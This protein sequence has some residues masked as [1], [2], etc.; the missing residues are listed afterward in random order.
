MM[1]RSNPILQ[2]KVIYLPS[3][4]KKMIDANKVC[5]DNLNKDILSV[6]D[7]NY[8]ESA[9]NKKIG[10]GLFEWLGFKYPVVSI[11]ENSDCGCDIP[12]ET[13]SN[14]KM[15]PVAFTSKKYDAHF[16]SDKKLILWEIDCECDS[17]SN[18]VFKGNL[19][20][21][22]KA[23]TRVMSFEEVIISGQM[24]QY[25]LMPNY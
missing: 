18:N 4:I 9:T 16:T 19:E 21:I 24:E 14:N 11:R 13:V 15:E 2:T 7:L 25:V 6:M 8:I 3:G 10:E 1:L 5:L 17:F 12:Y 22:L 23:M 20:R